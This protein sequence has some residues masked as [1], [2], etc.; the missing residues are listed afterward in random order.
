MLSHALITSGLRMQYAKY[1]IVAD[2]PIIMNGSSTGRAPIHVRIIQS[3]TRHQNIIWLIGQNLRDDASALLVKGR[4]N[5]IK[6]AS[7][8]AITP[9]SLLG[10][11]RRMAYT[12]RKYHS[13]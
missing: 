7:A 12:H 11:D 5:R 13:G 8:R 1:A 10:I 3:I 2:C 4:M 9:P 6:I